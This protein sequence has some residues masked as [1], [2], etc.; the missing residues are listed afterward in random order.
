MLVSFL[1]FDINWTPGKGQPQLRN[2]LIRSIHGQICGG[3][4]FRLMSGVRGPRSL[5]GAASGRVVL[6]CI[7]KAVQCGPVYLPR[8]LFKYLPP[9]SC[10]ERPSSI[11]S[12]HGDPVSCKLK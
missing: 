5:C 6:N 1:I 11:S 2:Y 4:F 9:P 3:I 8:S 10:L 12:L 7:R